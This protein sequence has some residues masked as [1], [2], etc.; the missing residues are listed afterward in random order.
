M[1]S[2]NAASTG[3]RPLESRLWSGSK[4]AAELPPNVLPARGYPKCCRP[5]HEDEIAVFAAIAS[6]WTRLPSCPPSTNHMQTQWP[7]H[8]TTPRPSQSATVRSGLVVRRPLSA[9][10]RS[11]AFTTKP[12]RRKP[13]TLDFKSTVQNSERGTKHNAIAS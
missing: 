10:G 3:Q 6:G 13:H 4:E 5:C 8:C 1:A 11:V 9:A 2:H 12:I 7:R